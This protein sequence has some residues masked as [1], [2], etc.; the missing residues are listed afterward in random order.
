MDIWP[1]TR[2]RIRTSRVGT[3]PFT[4]LPSLER[5][6]DCQYQNAVT[7]VQDADRGACAAALNAAQT[8]QSR[9]STDMAHCPVKL[10]CEIDLARSQTAALA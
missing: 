7:G 4:N 3:A 1:A 5:V 9:G 8:P 2:P 6:A 10:L